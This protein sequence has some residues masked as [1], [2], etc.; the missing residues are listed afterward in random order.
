MITRRQR[1]N[2]KCV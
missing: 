1:C 2:Q